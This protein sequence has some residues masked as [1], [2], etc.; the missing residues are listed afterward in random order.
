[1]LSLDVTSYER[2]CPIF[3]SAVRLT[4]AR[5]SH[6]R[7]SVE[8][9]PI[10]RLVRT[11]ERRRSGKSPELMDGRTLALNCA[12]SPDD[13]HYAV[14]EM[15]PEGDELLILPSRLYEKRVQLIGFQYP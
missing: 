9:D 6:L 15:H 1:M 14:W 12:N 2:R 8:T 11:D 7:S 10:R 4:A 13:V 3:R 5:S